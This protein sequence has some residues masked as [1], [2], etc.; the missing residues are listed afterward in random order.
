MLG[1]WSAS[2]SRMTLQCSGR[3]R[4]RRV[5]IGRSTIETSSTSKTS[6][7]SGLR[8]LWRKSSWLGMTPSNRCRVVASSGMLFSASMSMRP[9]RSLF[10]SR[11]DSARRCAALPVG[12][13]M[14]MRS[15]CGLVMASRAYGSY[16]ES[17]T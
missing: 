7:S 11:I 12:A 10:A 15:S 2:P 3:A 8:W 4:N 6:Q 9:A 1:S 5:I 14:Q 13:A 16:I 17:T